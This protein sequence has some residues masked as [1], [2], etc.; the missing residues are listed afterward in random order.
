MQALRHAGLRLERFDGPAEHFQLPASDDPADHGPQDVVVIAL[1]AYSIA[2][3]LPR[4]EPLLLPDTVVVT[5]ING[6]PWWYFQR[7]SGPHED[8]R[9]ATLDRDGSMARAIDS[10]RIIGCVVHASGE[11]AEPGLIRHTSGRLYLLGELD[12]RETARLRAVC[13]AMTAGGCDA[14]PTPSIR[15]EVWTKLIGNL[16]FNPVAALTL[17]RMHEICAN[18]G[19]ISLIRAMMV[20]AM[21][22]AE[23]YGER[24]AVTVE[25]RLE[26]ARALGSAKVSMHQDLERGRPMEIDAIIGSVV[27]LARRASIATP[28]IDAVFA[29]ITE[30]AR[31]LTGGG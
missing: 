22:V 12:G 1:K 21:R 7:L 26:I 27:E 8:L 28:A 25:K 17:A 20:E 2:A 4:L 11:V 29:L 13:E 14:R 19:L 10:S 23:H 9:I 3:M 5:A 24:V 31:H 16:S 15:N 30:R 6:L 18:S